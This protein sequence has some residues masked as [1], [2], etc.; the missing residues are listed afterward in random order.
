MNEV[1]FR[2][3]EAPT[4][5]VRIDSFNDFLPLLTQPNATVTT[6]TDVSPT[7]KD[8]PV[9]R[10]GAQDND[11]QQDLRD[12][13]SILVI[14]GCALC[15]GLLRSFIVCDITITGGQRYTNMNSRAT[16]RLRFDRKVSPDQAQPFAHAD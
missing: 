4:A 7:S 16:G 9:G 11:F 6:L 13:Q 14:D 12:G 1:D 8:D 5:T 3:A 2:A 15:S 10:K